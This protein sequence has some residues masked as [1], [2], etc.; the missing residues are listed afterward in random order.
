MSHR[1]VEVVVA[2][3]LMGL[4]AVVMWDS[5]KLGASWTPEGPQSGYFPFYV[6]LL[7]VLSSAVT[8]VAYL[9]TR[10]PNREPFV[11]RSRFLLVLKVLIPTIVYVAVIDY[12][13]IYVSTALFLA[14]FMRWLGRF[15]WPLVIVISLL[16][17][18]AFFVMFE[19]A[20]L[21]PLPKGPLEVY[22]GY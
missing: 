3:L 7:I 14:V 5:A 1:A 11:E 8:F 21:V 4:G 6:G 9:V 22:L 19:K 20:F 17:P 12:L 15:G 16:V 13:G 18:L 10:H 2:L